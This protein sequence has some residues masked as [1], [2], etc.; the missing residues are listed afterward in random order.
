MCLQGLFHFQLDHQILR[1][2]V[3]DQNI[4]LHGTFLVLVPDV[5]HWLVQLFPM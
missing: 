1:K 4:P 3:F 5:K 2:L